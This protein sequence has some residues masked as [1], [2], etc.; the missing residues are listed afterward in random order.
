MNDSKLNI[1]QTVRFTQ[2]FKYLFSKSMV[3]FQN[4]SP[5]RR[6]P[7][8]GLGGLYSIECPRIG[9]KKTI[10]LKRFFSP[11]R[12]PAGPPQNLFY[13]LAF[14]WGPSI[15]AYKGENTTKKKIYLHRLP[16]WTETKKNHSVNIYPCLACSWIYTPVLREFAP[17]VYVYVCLPMP[18][19][20]P[21]RFEL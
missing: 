8:R 17:V 2:N 21:R 14:T 10:S 7:G 4:F 16:P 9:G 20:H 5:R 12:A 18:N 19:I 15:H 11:T 3:P 6:G 1:Y 13:P